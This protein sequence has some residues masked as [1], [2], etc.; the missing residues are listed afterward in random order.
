MNTGTY[1]AART[2]AAARDT[3]RATEVEPAGTHHLV[4]YIVDVFFIAL[5]AAPFLIFQ[6]PSSVQDAVVG[7]PV[8]QVAPQAAA[9]PGYGPE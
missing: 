3:P 7:T 2:R 8:V 9:D 5:L 6:S 1:H 4:D